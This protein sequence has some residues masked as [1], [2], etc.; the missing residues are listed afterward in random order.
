MS[1]YLLNVSEMYRI[2]TEEEVDAFINEVKNDNTY[3][4]KKYHCEYKE[5]KSK[6]EVIDSWYR[7]SLVKVFTDE[8]EPERNVT[9]NY[10][11]Q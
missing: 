6:G 4:L 8:K 11:V 2:D 10:E 9:V 7:F 1:K 3:E 5:L